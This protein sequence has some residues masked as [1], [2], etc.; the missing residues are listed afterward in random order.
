MAYFTLEI[1]FLDVFFILF[2]NTIKRIA[3]YGIQSAKISIDKGLE[4]IG[5]YPI[6]IVSQI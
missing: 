6:E 1:D 4:I 3:N 2:E 5:G